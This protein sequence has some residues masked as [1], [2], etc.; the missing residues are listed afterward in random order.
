MLKDVARTARRRP[1]DAELEILAALWSN[2]PSTVRQLHRFLLQT[3]PVHYNSVLKTLQIMLEKKLVL[4]DDSERPQVYR[5]AA[6]RGDTERHFIKDLTARLFG[7]S[8]AALVLRA[9]ST[10][11]PSR[12]ELAALRKRLDQLDERGHDD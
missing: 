2:G 6:P 1:T 9:L 3:R 10:H 7:G 12:D 8:A 4:R 11:R 5:A